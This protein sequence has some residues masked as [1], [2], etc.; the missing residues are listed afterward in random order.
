MSSSTMDHFK[1][2]LEC[3]TEGGLKTGFSPIDLE[4]S[5]ADEKILSNLKLHCL[6]AAFSIA[7]S[8]K[9]D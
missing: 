8:Y 7:C 2:C 3:S 9:S 5:E 4:E 6:V 1:S